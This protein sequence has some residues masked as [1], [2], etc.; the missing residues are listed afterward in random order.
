[1]SGDDDG[2]LWRVM[3]VMPGAHVTLCGLGVHSVGGSTALAGARRVAYGGAF[4]VA[5]GASLA[6]TD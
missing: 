2:R 1:M 3:R 5:R 6:L 4:H